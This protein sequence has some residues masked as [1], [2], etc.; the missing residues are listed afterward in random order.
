M[1]LYVLMSNNGDGWGIEGLGRDF[2]L[3][4]KQADY[5]DKAK[6]YSI[7]INNDEVIDYETLIEMKPYYESEKL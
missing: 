3:L 7:E 6:I 5:D 2:G 1:E 4:A